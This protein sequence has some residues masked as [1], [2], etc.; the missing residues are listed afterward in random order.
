MRL[1]RTN[2]SMVGRWWWTVD[3]YTLIALAIL[4]GIGAVL[5]TAASPPVA[6]RIG[7]DRFYFV[8]RQMVFLV[9]SCAVMFGISL[10][11][12]VQVRRLAV[13][14]FLGSMLL[15]LLVPFI[16]FEVKGASRWIYIAGISIQP[17]EFM[18]PCMAVVT[19]WIF[20]EGLKT[21]GFPGY[22]VATA[23]YAFVVLLLLLQPDFG[24]TVTVSVVWGAQFFLAGLPFVYVIGL[25]ALGAAGIFG[26]YHF[27]SHVQARIDRFLDPSSGDNYQVAKSLEAFQNGGVLGQGPGEGIVKLHLP[28]SHTD[29]V[30]AVA[31]EEFGMILCLMIIALFAFIVLR[32]FSRVWKGRDMFVMLSVVGLLTQFGIQA[33]I[34]MG[35][36]VNMLPAKG[37]TLPFLSYGGS[38]LM[39][40]ALGMGMVLALTRLR[41]GYRNADR[42]DKERG[43]A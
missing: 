43:L 22:R 28:D 8:K 35:V 18:K 30:F 24:M 9:L 19:A 15:M 4:I 14:G 1:S 32:G 31:G 12:E 7:L 27:F 2:T 10:L 26:A 11:D 25:L 13:I 42:F 38:S 29:F 21:P 20:S 3:R 5:V 41:Y 23:L 6:E 37:M 16:G 17:S 33:V 34:N 39:A 40:V 36:A